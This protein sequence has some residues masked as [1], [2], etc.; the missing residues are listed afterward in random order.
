MLLRLDKGFCVVILIRDE[1]ISKIMSI[2]NNTVR[3]I[4][5][6]TQK[7]LKSVFRK[8]WENSWRKM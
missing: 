2:L 8:S 3:L 7:D 1:H 4:I 5:E 6:N